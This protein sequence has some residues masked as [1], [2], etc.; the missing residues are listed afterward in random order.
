MKKL[1]PVVEKHYQLILWLLPKI[2]N[3]PKD[4]RFLLADRIEC[5]LLDILEML[6]EAVYS[7]NK[8]EILIKVNLKLDCL[9]FMMRIAKDMK[10]VNLSAYDFFC[11]SSIEVGR[12]VGGWMKASD[13]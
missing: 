6:I 12:M 2:G 13:F 8:R 1:T 9:R 4:Q 5:I 3:F 11:R 10:Y 7:K